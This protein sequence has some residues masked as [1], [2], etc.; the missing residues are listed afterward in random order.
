[1]IATASGDTRVKVYQLSKEI[2]AAKQPFSEAAHTFSFDKGVTAIKFNTCADHIVAAGSADSTVRLFDVNAGTQASVIAGKHN[3]AVTDLAWSFDGKLFA[4]TSKDKFLRL[5]DPRANTVVA[6]VEAHPG[7]KPA[8][9]TFCGSTGKL[10]STGFSKARDRQ[11]AIWDLKSFATPLKMTNLDQSTGVLMPFYDNDT[12]LFF[13]GGKGDGAVRSYEINE[14]KTVVS[15]IG[16][17]ASTTPSRGMALVPKRALSHMECEVARILK[18]TKDSVDPVIFTVPRKS[19]REFHDD[20]FPNTRGGVAGVSASGWLAGQDGLPLL[21]SLRPG[22]IPDSD[23]EGK[24]AASSASAS[25]PA[26]ASA[27]SAPAP[28]STSSANASPATLSTPVAAWNPSDPHPEDIARANGSKIIRASKY[29][30]ISG[31]AWKKE[32]CYDHLRPGSSE[33]TNTIRANSTF[34]AVPWTGAGGPLAVVPI[35]NVGRVPTETPVLN[36]HSAAIVDFDFSP[37]DDTILATGSEDTHIKL[38]KIPAE[39]LKESTD[40]ATADLTGHG[41]KIVVLGFHPTASNVLLSASYDNSIRVWDLTSAQSTLTLNAHPDTIFSANWSYNGSNVVTASRDSKLRVFDIRQSRAIHEVDSHPTAKGARAIFLGN[42]GRILSSGYSREHRQVILWDERKMGT[43][44]KKTDIDVGAGLL[45]PFY[46]LGT[47][48]IFLAGKGD[49]MVRTYEYADEEPILHYLSDYRGGPEPTTGLAMLPKTVC[50]VRNCEFVRFLKLS[51]ERVEVIGWT[52]PR[53][54]ME[55]FQDDVFPLHPAAQPVLT[56]AEWFS[57]QTKE[58]N[59]V[60]LQ[61]AGMTA[62]SDAPK[63]EKQAPK[64]L[65]GGKTEQT[66]PASRDQVM[67][68][69]FKKVLDNKDPTFIPDGGNKEGV[70]ESEWD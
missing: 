34:F 42:T 28:A 11:F 47:G 30:H 55:F 65:K 46:D 15:E 58:P 26:A 21:V 44:L 57:G 3:D 33:S 41:H 62:L 29:R 39:G 51:K 36:G 45:L 12:D 60:S 32:L 54:R 27:S 14:E 1:M 52:V 10:L 48:V 16:I 38:W 53:T 59:L 67:D 20:L 24:P 43:P 37:F 68:G 63:V 50:D 7:L 2:V 61:P 23:G 64:Y 9:V 25:A 18:L 19:M 49:A 17:V 69:L 4:T 31:K 66:G 56:H 22:S 6:E 35:K 40:A 70:D 8:R 5:F 13:L